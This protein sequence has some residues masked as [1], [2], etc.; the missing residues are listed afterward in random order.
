M[1]CGGLGEH[2]CDDSSSCSEFCS[3]IGVFGKRKCNIQQ[4]DDNAVAIVKEYRH[5]SQFDGTTDLYL[6]DVISAIAESRGMPEI[7]VDTTAGAEC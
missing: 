3:G 1:A 2:K 4:E 7:W 6:Q 5:Y